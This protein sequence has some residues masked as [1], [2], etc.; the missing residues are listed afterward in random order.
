MQEVILA[1]WPLGW[2]PNADDKMGDIQGLLRADNLRWN[3]EGALI[4]TRG[5]K[6][7]SSGPFSAQVTKI[8]S[9]LFNLGVYGGTGYPIQAKVRYVHL[10]DGTILRNYGPSFKSL[11]DFEV[12]VNSGGD[13]TKSAFVSA[14]GHVYTL[15]GTSLRKDNGLT[16]YNLGIPA[17]VAPSVSVNAPPSI[18]VSVLNAGNFT[19][20]VAIEN[21]STYVDTGDYLQI[22]CSSTSFRGVA[23]VGSATTV[24]LDTTAFGAVSGRDTVNDMFKFNVRPSDTSTL[25]SVRLEFLLDT[26]VFPATTTED[27]LNYFWY[28]WTVRAE[29]QVEVGAASIANTN[30][31]ITGNEIN[32]ANEELTQT[33]VYNSTFRQGINT[34]SALQAK[35]GD[36]NRVG[37]DDGK[38]WTNVKG[39][40]V[41]FVAVSSMVLTFND[42]IFEG[43]ET[44]P[45]TGY[46]KWLQTDCRQTSYLTESLAGTETAEVELKSASLIITPAVPNEQA[47]TIRIYR[48]GGT[49]PG[50]YLVKEYP[51][52][53][54][55]SI[56][57]AAAAVVTRNNHNL[58]NGNV[59]WFSDGIGNWAALNGSRIVTV[60][61][62]NTFSVPVNSSGFGAV[63][64]QIAYVNYSPFTD[65]LSD[66]DA[67]TLNQQLDIFRTT[68]PPEIV[69]AIPINRRVL[70]FTGDSC[71]PSLQD[72][73]EMTDPRTQFTISGSD[74][75]TIL[76][77]AQVSEGTIIVGTRKDLVLLA[78]TF[79]G[80]GDG[81]LDFAVKNLQ[82]ANPPVSPTFV[83]EDSSLLY[84]TANGWRSRVGTSDQEISLGL[85]N[86]YNA[87]ECHG[88]TPIDY[89][90]DF[91]CTIH[92]GEFII[93]SSHT[94]DFGRSLQCFSFK[95][96]VWRME[97]L[98][99]ESV[100]P[101]RPNANAPL[102]IYTEDDGTLL[103][104]TEATGDKNL[105]EYNIGDLIDETLSLPFKLLTV[106]DALGKPNNRKDCYTLVLEADFGPS[107]VVNLIVRGLQ[108]DNSIV[109][110]TF[111]PTYVNQ[112]TQSFNLNGIGLCKRIQ[113]ELNSNA[114]TKATIVQ[115]GLVLDLRPTQVKSLR[116]PPT[117]WGT[118]SRKRV[119]EFPFLIDTLGGNVIF[120]PTVDGIVQTASTVNTTDAVPFSHLFTTDVAGYSI[121]G[122]L[123][124]DEL[125]EF[126]DLIQP[127]E[128]ETLPDPLKFKRIPYTNLGTVSRKRFVRYAIV[129]D[130]RG[131][132][133]TVTPIVD[134]INQPSLVVNTNRKQTVVLT[135]TVNVEGTDI[136]AILSGTN[137]FEFYGVNEGECVFEKLPAKSRFLRIQTNFGSPNKKRIRTL[138]FKLLSS[139]GSVSL[140]PTVDGTLYP[141]QTFS[142]TEPRTLFY[143]FDFDVFG[144]DLSIDVA[145]STDFE[146]YDLFAPE[147]VE[148]LPVQKRFDQVGPID[149]DKIGKL[150]S[151]SLWTLPEGNLI[152]YLIYNND[153]LVTQGTFA[154]TPGI[155]KMYRIK[156]PKF[157]N[158][159]TLRFELKATAAFH[160]LGFE[161]EY[162]SVGGDVQHKKF[163]VGRQE[164]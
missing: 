89:T 163:K 119:P 36:F 44:S 109:T 54:P 43:G 127:R 69:A 100:S 8:F 60:L 83:T 111:T 157:V 6:I 102:I 113:I 76:F 141:I 47:N 66:I 84:L 103:A 65:S 30:F 33:I 32:S 153:F 58:S 134:G 138:P 101:A 137:V 145:S 124:G 5:S 70:Y 87:Y 41:S 25:I 88:I 17:P 28:E 73:P 164:R 12:A 105:R 112:E 91:S 106:F 130:T 50:Y 59:V 45:L 74:S 132:N 78:G 147:V 125:F 37:T 143:L 19:D 98:W 35:R 115:F 150:Y 99:D 2:T 39:I 158:F 61:S 136:G 94:G 49:L 38:N 53:Y 3:K 133:V 52:Q 114:V 80:L 40:R 57:N 13:L 154:V 139:G 135:F 151:F 23:Q 11:T 46:Y 67:K 126:Y 149:F 4:L 148:V 15:T 146:F 156:L 160:R 110:L 162:S 117:N 63:T 22:D 93:S 118:P 55:D 20:W 21:G 142:S 18:N 144:I 159:Y 1:S 27:V 161:L 121:G 129:I 10:Q 42:L 152:E 75:D 96:K 82:V 26:P 116:I 90:G 64:G 71:Y 108:Q 122:T 81:L 62:A 155:E 131:S 85:S 123:E 86:L 120:T 56:S 29:N 97:K 16:Q 68:L 9:Q 79:A 128:V 7:V 140:T 34:W 95:N 77:A 51:I 104:G 24:N 92:K 72:D 107:A 31:E 48:S 14:F